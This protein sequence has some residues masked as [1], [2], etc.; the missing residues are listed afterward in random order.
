[1]VVLRSASSSG[2]TRRMI[3]SVVPPGGNGTMMRIGLVVQPCAAAAPT[4]ASAAQNPNA[5]AR[6]TLPVMDRFPADDERMS[7]SLG[8]AAA[9][10]L[11]RAGLEPRNE[12]AAELD[13]VVERIEAADQE[14]V[15]AERVVLEH[16]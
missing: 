2:W 6:I 14:R 7:T 5:R 16:R 4:N 12:L 13:R 8:G 1:M 15:D 3:W 9:V 11:D 10:D